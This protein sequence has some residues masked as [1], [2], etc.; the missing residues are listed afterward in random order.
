MAVMIW[1]GVFL[2][3]FVLGIV[4]LRDGLKK[5]A[6][7]TANAS[8]SKLNIDYKERWL[9]A[10][11]LLGDTGRLSAEEVRSIQ[12]PEPMKLVTKE[13]Q[14]VTHALESG[15]DSSYAKS[16]RHYHDTLNNYQESLNRQQKQL[17][18]DRLRHREQL[19]A[20]TI[21]KPVLVDGHYHDAGV[22]QGRRS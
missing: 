12:A 20:K 21:Y 17:E 22:V 4:L 5:R 6:A 15:K 3:L 18:A 8:P 2:V 14:S 19:D 1:I 11:N 9:S 7:E 13:P 16:L 10:V